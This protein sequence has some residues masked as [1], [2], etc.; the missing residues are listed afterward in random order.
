MPH[1]QR[2]TWTGSRYTPGTCRASLPGFR[3]LRAAAGGFRGETLLSHDSRHDGIHCRQP[4]YAIAIRSHP[5]AVVTARFEP[6]RRWRILLPG[7]ARGSGA[8]TAS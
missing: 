6:V 7:Y 5:S 8:K 2:L 1:M 4:I 3:G